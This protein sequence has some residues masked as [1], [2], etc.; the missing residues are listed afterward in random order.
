MGFLRPKPNVGSLARDVFPPS[1]DPSAIGVLGRKPKVESLARDEDVEGLVE[2]TSY[3]ELVRTSPEAVSDLG[4]PVRAEAILA[5]SELGPEAGKKA[6]AGALRDPADS[7]RCAAVRVLHA[8]QEADA[9]LEA[10]R[11]LPATEGES[12]E[13]ALRAVLGLRELVTPV[14]LADAMIHGEHEELL[15][16]DDEPLIESLIEQGGGDAGGA[17][18]ELLVSSLADERGIVVDR[19]GEL[20][21]RL[22]PAGVEALV[23]ELRSG[24]AASEAA[25]VLGTIADRKTL[26][27][28]VEGLGH[29]D[30]RVRAESAAALSE[31]RDPAAVKPLLAATHDADHGVRTQA[32]RALDG[33]GTA[34]VIVGVAALLEPVIRE[35]AWA[36]AGEAEGEAK[37]RPRSEARKPRSRR[38]NGGPPD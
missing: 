12:R 20:L 21:R 35:A 33:L 8:R 26:G 15:D 34:A 38:S 29:N 9:L 10:L 24:P 3:Y 2:A 31:L 32:T 25:Y 1:P 5:L 17:L 23:A 7:V 36:G 14:V 27:P 37:A 13:L 18:I 28:L 19:A 16:E 6:V 22:A 11:W 30:P 4:I